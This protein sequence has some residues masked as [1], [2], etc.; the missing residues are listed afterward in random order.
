[1]HFFLLLL[2]KYKNHAVAKRTGEMKINGRGAEEGIETF[3]TADLEFELKLNMIK[4]KSGVR[5]APDSVVSTMF[6]LLMVIFCC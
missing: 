1:M 4:A 6:T 3:D 2:S 5:S